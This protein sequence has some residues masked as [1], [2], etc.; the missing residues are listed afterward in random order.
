MSLNMKKRAAI[1]I[2]QLKK[3]TGAARNALEQVRLFHSLGYDVTVIG[4]QL[5][6]N[7]IKKNHGTCITIGQFPISG[8]WRRKYF[9]W[10]A[11]KICKNG[12]FDIVIGHGDH[13]QQDIL[14]LHNLVHLQSE[15]VEKVAVSPSYDVGI[16]HTNIIKKSA[17]RLIIANSK[18]MKNDLINRFHV[19]SEKIE[20][21]FQSYNK[22]QFNTKN[23]SEI[24]HKF[25]E[26]LKAE[27][28][29]SPNENELI[30]GLI[31]SGEF[32]TRG[33]D[34]AL[35]VLAEIKKKY[36]FKFLVTGRDKN[37]QAYKDL[38]EELGLKENVIFLET[39]PDVEKY[40]HALDIFFLPARFETFGRSIL[41]AMA[42][43]LPVL[44]SNQTGASEIL[45]SKQLIKSPDDTAGWV[46][47]LE[48]L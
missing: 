18:I 17:Y 3:T 4:D 12:Q 6:E 47:A 8:I 27:H 35:T 7:L 9:A 2:R 40:Y 41:E 22:E 26:K 28:K 25:F 24:R 39:T 31:T 16:M 13:F 21:C 33:L 5:D 34:I 20:I 10:R 32:K 42:C 29:F 48:E 1:V 46:S 11:D 37:A 43:G 19:P 30:I 14:V 23:K 15:L 38:S 45:Q 36:S 44:T